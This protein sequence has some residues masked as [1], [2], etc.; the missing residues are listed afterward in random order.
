MQVEYHWASSKRKEQVSKYY[1]V[2]TQRALGILRGEPRSTV[3]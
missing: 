3:A 2:V 1:R